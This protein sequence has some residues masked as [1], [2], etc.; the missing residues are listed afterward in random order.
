MAGVGE[1]CTHVAALLFYLEALHRMEEVQ[2]CTQQQCGWIVPSASTTVRYLEV[3]DIDF[4][5]A[6]GKKRKLD[7]MLEGSE[8]NSD[9]AVTKSG[10]SPTDAKMEQFFNNLSL[11]GTKPAVLSL[12]SPHSD[13]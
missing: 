11:C 3:K 8:E 2:I 7:E 12:V 5:S 10:T 6:R 4:T 9:V 13:I 1:V